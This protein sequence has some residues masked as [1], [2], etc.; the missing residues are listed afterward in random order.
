MKIHGLDIEKNFLEEFRIFIPS[1]YKVERNKI[2]ARSGKKLEFKTY[3]DKD[4]V[5]KIFEK[6]KESPEK[7]SLFLSLFYHFLIGQYNDYLE[8]TSYDELWK[9]SI[10]VAEDLFEN[11]TLAKIF[12]CKKI[13]EECIKRPSRTTFENDENVDLGIFKERN[14][15]KIEKNSHFE[16]SECFELDKKDLERDEYKTKKL[17]DEISRISSLIRKN[18]FSSEQAFLALCFLHKFFGIGYCNLCRRLTL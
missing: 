18:T 17:T 10:R 12:G 4:C 14:F 13:Q 3:D 11:R 8:E 1:H 9:T 6:S 2:S 16:F 5:N 7:Y 15:Y